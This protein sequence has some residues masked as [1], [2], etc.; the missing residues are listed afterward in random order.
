MLNLFE[1]LTQQDDNVKLKAAIS[2]QAFD[3]SQ[4][5]WSEIAALCVILSSC[6]VII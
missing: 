3:Y 1:I 2:D 6:F 4:D 5:D